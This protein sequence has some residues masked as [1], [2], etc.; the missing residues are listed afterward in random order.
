MNGLFTWDYEGQGF[1][2]S[3]LEIG[4]SSMRGLW[5]NDGYGWNNDGYSFRR[6]GLEIGPL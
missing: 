5:N 1:R 6:D 2:K 4:L 3:G